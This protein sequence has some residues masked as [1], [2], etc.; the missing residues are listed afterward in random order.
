MAPITF[1][2]LTG[3]S[4]IQ[5]LKIKII[6]IINPEPFIIAGK[7]DWQLDAGLKKMRLPASRFF[8]VFTPY[9]DMIAPCLT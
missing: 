9:K 7:F 5:I 2:Y 3:L 1:A 6:F 4:S 8:V